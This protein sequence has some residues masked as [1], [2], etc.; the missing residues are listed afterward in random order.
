MWGI[1]NVYTR[2]A[3]QSF[4]PSSVGFLRYLI[5]AAMLLA[6]VIFKRISPPKLK[7]AWLFVLSGFT[8]FAF[9]M[10]SYNMGYVTVTAATGSVISATIPPITAVLARAFLDEKLQPVQWAAIAIQ[11]FGIIIIALS[12]GKMSLGTGV[13]WLLA[14]AVS[15]AVYNLIQRKLTVRYCAM[16][17]SV[18]SIFCG[19]A[20][21][22]IFSPKAFSELSQAKPRPIFA[23]V[24]LGVF[25]SAVAFLCWTKAFSLA[26]KASQVSNFM[27]F[28]PLISTSF[29]ILLLK[30]VPNPSVL[31]GGSVILLGA[32]I[33]KMKKTST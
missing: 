21:M 29:E 3:L 19:W 11:F 9:Y 16:Q 26:E 6:L 28:T 18:Y 4:S 25:A 12:S 15:L 1:G 20:M 10:F 17:S 22:L 30:E 14:S 2:V 31:L 33:F 13:M 27:F 7:D 24:F 23:V 5:A 8:G 32:G